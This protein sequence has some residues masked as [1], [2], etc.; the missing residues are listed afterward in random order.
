MAEDADLTHCHR[1]RNFSHSRPQ[2]DRQLE[3]LSEAFKWMRT[4]ENVPDG[5]ATPPQAED[6]RTGP[7]RTSLN[8]WP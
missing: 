6:L 8:L 4:G 5:V 7:E 1:P 3:E 2:E